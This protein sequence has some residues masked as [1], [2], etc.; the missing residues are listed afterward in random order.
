MAR[1]VSKFEVRR[2][3]EKERARLEELLASRKIR[4]V[5]TTHKR[6][7]AVAAPEFE[8]TGPKAKFVPTFWTWHCEMK[9]HKPRTWC[10]GRS[11]AASRRR[12]RRVPVKLVAFDTGSM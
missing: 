3:M 12:A 9:R 8:P 11:R 6:S 7:K 4:A 5:I 2:N 10:K 1:K